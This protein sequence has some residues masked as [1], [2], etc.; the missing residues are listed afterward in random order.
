MKTLVLLALLV[1][2]IFFLWECN[3]ERS[4]SNNK[5]DP[6]AP[7]QIFLQGEFSKEESK[8]SIVNAKK[9]VNKKTEDKKK[10]DQKKDVNKKAKVKK[11]EDKKSSTVL[12]S[13]TSSKDIVK[14]KGVELNTK[15]VGKKKEVHKKE[16]H[17]KNENKKS[18]KVL[19][20]ATPSKDIAKPK[21]NSTKINAKTKGVELNTKAE[22]SGL[23][24]RQALLKE[25]FCFQ[26]G[27]FESKD[28]FGK[29]A[30][31]NNIDS[32]LTKFLNKNV[33]IFRHYMVYFP[34]AKTIEI[35]KVNFNKIKK[36]DVAD[37]WLFK[38][39]KYKGGISLG[40]YDKKEP[41]QQLI[42]KY[43]KLKIESE[44]IPIYKTETTL[45]SNISTMD[46]DFK[47]GL[48]LS[49][50]QIVVSCEK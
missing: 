29:W 6:N 5:I 21:L 48:S 47:E 10:E 35:S 4:S 14:T 39:G 8:T 3:S 30:E 37:I 45:Y 40:L 17:K 23:N 22:E 13:A 1:N 18:A 42:E 20:S 12:S 7:K 41:A 15:K 32:A 46:K 33:E 44:I 2:I 50:T 34:K 16:V 43:A 28:S 9:E 27:P 26:V 38:S 36:L 25:P 24:T 19:S 11:N 49:D 31:L